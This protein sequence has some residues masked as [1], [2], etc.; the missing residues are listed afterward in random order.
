MRHVTQPSDLDLLFA[1]DLAVLYK[2]SPTCSICT[3]AAREVDRFVQRHPEAVVYQVDVL[4]ARPLSHEIAART[5]VTHESPQV[6]LLRQGT[7]LWQAS[8]F[9]ITA[10]TL[11]TRFEA[12]C[13]GPG[14]SKPSATK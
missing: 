9:T 6:I 11:A 8:H 5:G 3:A 13:G 14:A 1:E 7:P 2:H 12:A 4:A 10:D